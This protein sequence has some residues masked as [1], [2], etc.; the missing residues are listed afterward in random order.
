MA[1]IARSAALVCIATA[2]ACADA[3]DDIIDV[4]SLMAGALTDVTGNGELT[5]RGNV[6]LF[7]SE[8]SKD[9]PDYG[10]LKTDVTALV[11]ETEVSSSIQVVSDEGNDQK[12]TV[13]LDWVLQLQSLERDGPLVRRREVIHCEFRKEKKHWKIVSLKPIDFFAPPQP[14]Q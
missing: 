12:R 3:H 13:D 10:T 11:R 1:A 14:G 5:V 8:F 7:M 6:P 4:F 9:M 2:F